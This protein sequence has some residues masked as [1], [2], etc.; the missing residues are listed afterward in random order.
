MAKSKEHAFIREHPIAV[1][2][3]YLLILEFANM[4]GF[5]RPFRVNIFG[6]TGILDSLTNGLQFVAD[7]FIALMNKAIVFWF[8]IAVLIWCR[9]LVARIRGK[10]RFDIH[11]VLGRI[12]PGQLVSLP[13]AF[14]LLIAVVNLFW[15]LMTATPYGLWVALGSVSA[16]IGVAGAVMASRRKK[17]GWGRTLRMVTVFLAALLPASVFIK[18]ATAAYSI[19]RGCGDVRLSPASLAALDIRD[20]DDL[21]VYLGH[22]EDHFFFY[23]D[24]KDEV[25]V[26]KQGDKKIGLVHS[27]RQSDF[28]KDFT[29]RGIGTMTLRVIFQVPTCKDTDF[30]R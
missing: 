2:T 27:P 24:S 8:V 21:P 16:A 22:A 29:E 12:Q 18:G 1:G 30:S 25:L 14:F 20:V 4:Y 7:G 3:L 17:P 10:P 5:W 13:V 6:F 9:N 23:D 26:L 28:W 19:K 15:A 11:D